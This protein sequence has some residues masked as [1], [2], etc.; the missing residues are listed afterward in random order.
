M[1]A[2]YVVTGG[3]QGDTGS[4]LPLGSNHLV[5]II[6]ISDIIIKDFLRAKIDLI[7]NLE[8][9]K[10]KSK[11]PVPTVPQFLTSKFYQVFNPQNQIFWADTILT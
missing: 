7:F 8:I 1:V 10:H 11:S 9:V 4:L 2:R 5:I 3:S 6:I